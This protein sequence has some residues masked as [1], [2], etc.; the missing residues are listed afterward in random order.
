M[1]KLGKMAC[2]V[3]RPGGRHTKAGWAGK[4]GAVNGAMHS[5]GGASLDVRY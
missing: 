1:Q 4:N 3:Q 5:C 2:G